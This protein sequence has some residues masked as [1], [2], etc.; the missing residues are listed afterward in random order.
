MNSLQ[1]LFKIPEMS[2]A[3]RELS[4]EMMKAGIIEEMIQDTFESLEDT[5][6]LEQQ[7]EEE[8]QNVSIY[9][10]LIILLKLY[11]AV[12]YLIDLVNS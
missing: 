4:K 7:A 9:L 8:I 6:E 12:H 1:A 10:L 2:A 5:E 11:L 3:M